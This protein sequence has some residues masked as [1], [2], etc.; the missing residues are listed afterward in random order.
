MAAASGDSV[1][2]ES[3]PSLYSINEDESAFFKQLTNIDDDEKLKEHIIAIQ[4]ESLQV[5]LIY[6]SKD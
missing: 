4:R 3:D 5:R 1:K 2:Y 6:I